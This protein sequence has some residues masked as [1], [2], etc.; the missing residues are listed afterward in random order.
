V[1]F[2][3][4][5]PLLA[6]VLVGYVAGYGVTSLVDGLLGGALG[7]RT[8]EVVGWLSGLVLLLVTVRWLLRRRRRA[9]RHQK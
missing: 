1:F 9:T 6:V 4:L 2:A 7:P 5:V 3:P 8:P